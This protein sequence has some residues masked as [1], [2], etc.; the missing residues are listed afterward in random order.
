MKPLALSLIRLYQKTISLD[1]GPLSYIRPYG[2]CKFYPSCSEYAYQ[3]IISYGLLKG[4]AIGIRRLFRCV[5]WSEG[6]VDYVIK[7]S[8]LR[9]QYL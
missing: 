7:N 4:A 9:K 3:A 6:G 2:Q 1:H 8:K 5:P